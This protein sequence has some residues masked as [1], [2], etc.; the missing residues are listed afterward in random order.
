MK[1]LDE[2]APWSVD[3]EKLR[4]ALGMSIATFSAAA[5]YSGTYWNVISQRFMPPADWKRIQRRLDKLKGEGV[6]A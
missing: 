6:K 4:R 3:Y 1:K 2:F 5:G